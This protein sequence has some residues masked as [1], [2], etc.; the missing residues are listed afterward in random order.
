MS[1]NL[2]VFDS[3]YLNEKIIGLDNCTLLCSNIPKKTPR[4]FFTANLDKDCECDILVIRIPRVSIE[5]YGRGD[6]TPIRSLAKV[7][8]ATNTPFVSLDTFLSLE[9]CCSLI[10]MSGKEVLRTVNNLSGLQEEDTKLIDENACTSGNFHS[11]N[12]ITSECS[13]V[14]IVASEFGSV[15]TVTSECGSV[16]TITT[17]VTSECGLSSD[18]GIRSED[19]LVNLI[20]TK[21]SEMT[22][23]WSEKDKTVNPIDLS[24]EEDSQEITV[25]SYSQGTHN[26]N[27]VVYRLLGSNYSAN[28]IFANMMSLSVPIL[29]WDEVELPRRISNTL[30]SLSGRRSKFFKHWKLVESDTSSEDTE[31]DEDSDLEDSESSL[32]EFQ[33]HYSVQ[34]D[35][36]MF[37]VRKHKGVK[38]EDPTVKKRKKKEEDTPQDELD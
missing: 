37:K 17:T 3:D 27:N 32:N 20:L 9:L 26:V 16:N 36:N 18:E 31:E 4:V 7:V 10:V 33:E 38:Q 23:P 12:T 28:S 6:F 19:D 8:I 21:E 30:D 24:Q 1:Y 11:V 13:S 15:N 14:N 5:A 22:D 35:E 29:G 25:Y 2:Y 34:A